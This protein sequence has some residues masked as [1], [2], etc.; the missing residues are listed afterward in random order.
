M[1]SKVKSQATLLID[2]LE[3]FEQQVSVFATQRIHLSEEQSRRIADHVIK[4]HSKPETDR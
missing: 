1:G 2:V 3:L 4:L